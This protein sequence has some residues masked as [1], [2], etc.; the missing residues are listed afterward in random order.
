MSNEAL[1]MQQNMR[2]LVRPND[3][4]IPR[5]VVKVKIKK[6]F[7][8]TIIPS[9]S[10]FGSGAC[11]IRVYP[12]MTYEN[13]ESDDAP[14]EVV[15][16]PGEIYFCH[17]GFATEFD[18]NLVALIYNRSGMVTKNKLGLPAGVYVIDSDYR[19][20]WLIPIQNRSNTPKILRSGDRVAQVI[21]HYCPFVTF[22][23]VDELSSSGRGNNGFGSTG[24]K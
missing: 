9:Y 6:L 18:E 23:E 16:Q 12:E 13:P 15:I 8:K 21:W 7:S 14:K 11:D 1:K 20:E 17:V 3:G 2:M 22:D 10:T 4:N 5:Y 19:G 24:V